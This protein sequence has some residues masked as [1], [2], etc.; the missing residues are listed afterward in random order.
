VKALSV[1]PFDTALRPSD[2]QSRRIAQNIQVMMQNEFN[3]TAPA[4]PAGG[5]WFVETLTGQVAEAAWGK[6]QDIEEEGGLKTALK[7]GSLQTSIAATLSER[8]KKL[9]ARAERIVGSNMYVNTQETSNQ[10][11]EVRGQRSE[12]CRGGNLPPA[13]A[14]P[15]NAT[16][17]ADEAGYCLGAVAA[18]FIKG[19]SVT[20]VKEVLNKGGGETV[21]AIEPHRLTE[22]FEALREKTE[23]H[24]AQ[25]GKNIEVFLANMG[26]LSQHKARADFSAGFMEV[27]GFTVLRNNGFADVKSAAAAAIASK[28]QAAVLCSTDDTYPEIVPPLARAI[29]E[30]APNMLV[31]LAGMPAP[32]FKE[33]YAEA[34]MDDF[35]H[36]KADCLSVLRRIQQ[37]GG[38]K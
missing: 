25:S 11:S 24:A 22:Q 31:I 15:V 28:A 37:A 7:S 36:I 4:A 38:I 1:E 33:A 20:Q 5:S 3:L 10:R 29:K 19:A 23:A 26:P 35:I 2:E 17:L 14:P 18:A 30:K 16:D 32:E 27:G 34:G 13:D 12:N 6:L 9:A 21:S 8:Y